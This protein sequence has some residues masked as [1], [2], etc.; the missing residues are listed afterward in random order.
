MNLRS[1]AFSLTCGDR[2]SRDRRDSLSTGS[3]SRGDRHSVN[4]K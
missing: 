3:I 4:E 2:T 1:N